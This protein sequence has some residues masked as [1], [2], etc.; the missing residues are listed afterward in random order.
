M[1][2]FL[3]RLYRFATRHAGAGVGESAEPAH[4]TDRALLRKLHQ[5]IHKITDD[6]DTRWHFNTSLAA[7][8][9]LV[10]DLYAHEA[11]M[12][13]GVLREVVSKTVLLMG[14]FAPHLAEQLWREL[15]NDGFILKKPWPEFDPV[16]AR[17]N[18]IEIPVQVNGKLRSRLTIARGGARE[19][20]EQLAQEDKKIQPHIDGKTIR[21][22]VVVPDKLVNIVV[23]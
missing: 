15:G 5:T 6:F 12:S 18:K 23:R 3:T 14:P 10:N 19:D 4:D 13:A 22:I 9:E 17:E 21:K 1:Q 11:Q 16:L 8:M 7:L 20:I 2:R